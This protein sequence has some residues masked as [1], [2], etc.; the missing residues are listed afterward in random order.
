MP[1]G[2]SAAGEA[3]EI[4]TSRYLSFC[5][6]LSHVKMPF[7]VRVRPGKWAQF[8]GLFSRDDGL[9]LALEAKFHQCPVS[10]ATPG[11]AARVN[12]AKEMGLAGII[13]ASRSGFARD[14]CRLRLPIEKVLLSWRGMRKGLRVIGGELLTAALDRVKIVRGGFEAA[15]GAFLRAQPLSGGAGAGDG[16]A[17]TSAES[18]RW[19]RRLPASEGDITPTP[20]RARFRPGEP[21][22]LKNAWAVEDSLRGFAP[23]SPLA[24]ERSIDALCEGPVGLH[25][26]WRRLWKRGYRG[27][28]GGL[29]NALDNLCVLGVAEKFQTS[30]GML[31]GLVPTPGGKRD[32]QAVLAE[33]V[34]SWPAFVHFRKTAS[35]GNATKSELASKLSVG[36]EP[37]H[38]YARSL[39]NPAKVSGLM[40]L[41]DYVSSGSSTTRPS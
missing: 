14:I 31:H 8:D 25:D 41:D 33:A 4:L 1:R 19:L 5:V 36:F 30:S 12:F 7:Y 22:D 24:M 18:E 37:F 3:F 6:G 34:T 27:R 15:S 16:F 17:F 11:I 26:A 13:L 28:E 35:M 29:K 2:A 21:L 32:P 9:R 10:L 23:C 38:P 40:A 39:Y 20:A